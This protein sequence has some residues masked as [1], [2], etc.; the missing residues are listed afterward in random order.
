MVDG[1]PGDQDGNQ[2]GIAYSSIGTNE[3]KAASQKTPGSLKRRFWF[4]PEMAAI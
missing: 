4:R 3:P 1:K 2:I